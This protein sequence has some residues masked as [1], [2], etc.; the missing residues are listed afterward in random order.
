M[1]FDNLETAEMASSLLSYLE[2][3]YRNHPPIGAF[4]ALVSILDEPMK[5]EDWKRLFDAVGGNEDRMWENVK[6][7]ALFRSVLVSGMAF[8]DAMGA[9]FQFGPALK[10]RLETE[11]ESVPMAPLDPVRFKD[12]LEHLKGES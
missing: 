11:H 12:F 6:M 4:E 2:Y 9:F 3:L 5:A 10:F 7:N 8:Y 1:E